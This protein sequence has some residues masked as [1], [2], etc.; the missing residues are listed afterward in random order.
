MLVAHSL[1]DF[2]TVISAL[3]SKSQTLWYRGVRRHTYR[4]TPSLYRLGTATWNSDEYL[5]LE[6]RLLERFR[7]RS[8]PYRRREAP[9]D[10]ISY[11]FEMQH[12]GAPT[13]LL[14]W[15]ENAFMALWFALEVQSP[16]RSRV[17]VL[18][19]HRWNRCIYP[20]RSDVDRPLSPT[21]DVVNGWLTSA[22]PKR[23]QM[24]E[25]AI[26]I[27]GMHNSS[28]IVG[29]RGVFTLSGL[30]RLPLEEEAVAVAKAGGT[31][32]SELLVAVDIPSNHCDAVRSE[33]V[34]AG[35]SRSMI[36]PDLVGLAQELAERAK[37][38]SL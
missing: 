37:D 1:A 29:Q 24:S 26:C 22:T 18:D 5:D 38:G 2:V 6:E 20:S 19:P 32:A 31:R 36:Y 8:L 3:T 35:F 30:S 21:S 14:D 13:R 15:S 4:L 23:A 25:Q 16:H 7:E 12:Y 33:L 27:Y 10:D 9:P 11:F 17:W 34:R 28:R